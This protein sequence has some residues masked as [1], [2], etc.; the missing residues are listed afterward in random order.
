[1]MEI[2]AEALLSALQTIRAPFAGYEQSLH[3]QVEAALRRAGYEPRH[4]AFLSRGCRVDF[5]VGSI[6]IEIKKGKPDRSLLLQQISRYLS[7]EKVSALIVVCE[8]Q[9]TLPKSMMNKPVYGLSLHRLW[10]VALP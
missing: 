3:G 2:T 10:G 7:S 1:M 6:A 9:V 8:R 5:L 4:E